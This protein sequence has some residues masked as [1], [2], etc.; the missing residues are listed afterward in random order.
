VGKGKESPPEPECFDGA[1]PARATG[2]RRVLLCVSDDVHLID[3]YE[4]RPH[5]C[6][7]AFRLFAAGNAD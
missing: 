1:A 5:I 3:E 7:R 4:P 2:K 6:H